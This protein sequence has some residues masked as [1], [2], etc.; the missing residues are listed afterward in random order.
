MTRPI[1]VARR[2]LARA[3]RPGAG[4]SSAGEPADMVAGASRSCCA[5]G[6]AEPAPGA[7]AARVPRPAARPVRPSARACGRPR[8][9]ARRR[10][11]STRWV[12]SAGGRWSA[13]R[14]RASTRAGTATGCSS[15]CPRDAPAW[16]CPTASVSSSCRTRPGPGSR[17]RCHSRAPPWRSCRS[18]RACPPATAFARPWPR[19]SGGWRARVATG[20]RPSLA[21]G[22][23]ALVRPRPRPR[24][25]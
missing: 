21:A 9:P 15:G 3:G 5:T 17:G 2:A 4:R 6:S 22:P 12:Q 14:A 24:P 10:P 19:S 20:S 23:R 1:P 11:R 8:P 16:R 7:R 13:W 25:G 18:A